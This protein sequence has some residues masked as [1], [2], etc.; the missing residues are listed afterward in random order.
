MDPAVVR[1]ADVFQQVIGTGLLT[2]S[3][4]N[5]MFGGGMFVNSGTLILNGA[6]SL[7]AGSSL[8]IGSNPSPGAVFAPPDTS[9]AISRNLAPVPEPGTLLM[10]ATV[11]V[12]LS[13]ALRRRRKPWTL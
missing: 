12:G 3:G 11:A 4:T 8:T 6:G 10:L 9:L 7:L 1:A 5:N 2:L 13:V